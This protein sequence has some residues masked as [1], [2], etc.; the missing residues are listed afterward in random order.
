MFFRRQFQWI[1]LF[2]L[3]FS[4]FTPFGAFAQTKNT[5]QF[6]LQAQPNKCVALNQG[7]EC[8]AKMMINWRMENTSDYCLVIKYFDGKRDELKCWQQKRFGQ[9]AYEFQSVGDAQFLLTRSVDNKTVASTD[10]QISW[11]YKASARKRRWRLF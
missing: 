7:R 8:F 9:M 4:V 3:W 6:G 2:G 1:L 5:V 10:I 11:L